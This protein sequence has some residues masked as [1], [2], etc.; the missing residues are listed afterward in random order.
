M[1]PYRT[2]NVP[3]SADQAAIKQAYRKLA[4]ILHPDRNP[5]QRPGGAALQGGQPGL[6]PAVRSGQAGQVRSR[7]DRRR[8][9]AA[10]GVQGL[11]VRGRPAKRRRE[12]LR[13]D[14]RRRVRARLRRGVRRRPGTGRGEFRFEDLRREAAAAR[15]RRAPGAARRR[16]PLP[17]RGRLR[18]GGARRQASASI[19]TAAARS[20][21]AC[22]PAP[23]TAASLRLK[24]QGDGPR[25]ARPATPWSRSRSG[26]TRCSRARATTSTSNCRSACRKRCLGRASRCRRSMARCA[27][28]CRPAATAGGRS[29][30]RAAA[31]CEPEGRRGDQYV[32]LLVILPEAPD[33]ELEAVGKTAHLRRPARPRAE[34]SRA[35]AERSAEAHAGA[36]RLA[37]GPPDRAPCASSGWRAGCARRAAADRAG[38]AIVHLINDGGMTYAGHIAFMTLFSLFPF[39]IFLTTLAAE[40]GQTE[41]A[42]EFVTMVLEHASERG[43]RGDP[44]RRSSR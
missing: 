42:R 17:A 3:R 22:R 14:V 27:S 40:I 20:R 1:D 33:A 35:E 31:S 12:H 24:G 29:G 9:P 30:S 2:L 6:R 8:W 5:G 19:W 23:S 13:Q 37:A 15:A 4:K 10:P 7:R 34:V 18:R 26:R 32:R 28:P 44:S 16:S 38:S 11:R 21:S 39:L 25:A 43:Q 41:A 36:P